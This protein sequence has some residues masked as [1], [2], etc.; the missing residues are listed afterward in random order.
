M[1]YLYVADI[2]GLSE[3]MECQE[4]MKE[5]PMERQ[6]K[7]AQYKQKKSR[8]QSLGAGLLLNKVLKKH[9]IPVDTLRTDAS[10][11]PVVE[12]ICFNL[13]HSGTHVICAVSQKP[14][15]CDIEEVKNAPKQIE[16]RAFSPEERIHLKEL[17]CDAYNR[18]FYRLWTRKESFLKMK[19]IGIRVSLQTL[20]LTGCY[21]KEYE[22]PGYQVT[23]CAEENE[24]S[25]II[26]EKL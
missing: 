19:G 11:K 24:F 4:L 10:G 3:P 2:S 1:V 9:G 13:S 26:W 17:D 21:F 6:Q 23:V 7:I 15:G 8:M 25:E 22:L 20:E 16:G 14:V 18:E 5:L 12:G